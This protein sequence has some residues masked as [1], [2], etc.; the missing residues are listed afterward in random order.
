MDQYQ[1]AY[2]K[3]WQRKVDN[4]KITDSSGKY[5]LHTALKNVIQIEGYST[6]R[7]LLDDIF[8]IT[9]TSAVTN[10]NGGARTSTI[11]S[12]LIK[13]TICENITKGI[14]EV[15]APGFNAIIDFG[16]GE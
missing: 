14:K 12:P 2:L 7:N 5:W 10:S 16:N 6:R 3:R 11:I 9:G 4:G 8:S 13:K 15:K 1:Y